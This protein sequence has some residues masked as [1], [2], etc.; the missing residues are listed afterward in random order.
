VLLDFTGGALSVLQLV[1]DCAN[2]SDWGGITGTPVK[3]ALG[4][5]SMAFDTLFVLQHYILYKGHAPL[6]G[7]ELPASD[8]SY[9]K[10]S[11]VEGAPPSDAD[12]STPLSAKAI[13][14]G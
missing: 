6:A 13:S 3:F 14:S 1:L 2:T 12:A 8:R 5:V 10:L 9:H 7:E 4:F 11:S